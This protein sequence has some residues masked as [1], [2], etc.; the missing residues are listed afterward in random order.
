V[1]VF[2]SMFMSALWQLML[3]MARMHSWRAFDVFQ[4]A[5]GASVNVQL[6]YGRTILHECVRAFS[7]YSRNMAESDPGCLPR[8]MC[9]LLLSLIDVVLI[10]VTLMGA[11]TL[12]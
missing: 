10:C 6:E 7:L 9:A 12:C 3:L 5:T 2:G 4:K 8:E 1:H 11:K